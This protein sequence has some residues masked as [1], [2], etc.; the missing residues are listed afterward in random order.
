[1]CKPPIVERPNLTGPDSTKA[2]SPLRGG[3]RLIIRKI[4]KRCKRQIM[5][6]L[7]VIT[8]PTEI[9]FLMTFL[10]FNTVGSKATSYQKQFAEK[11]T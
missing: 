4:E 3:V 2:N 5:E 6:E 10:Y 9:V 11:Y 1:L 7:Q 8:K